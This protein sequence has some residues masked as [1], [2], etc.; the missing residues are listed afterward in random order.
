MRSIAH[1]NARYLRDRIALYAWE[2][3][4]RDKPWLTRDAVGLLDSW[5]RSNDTGLECGSGRS[6]V[7]FARRVAKMT[8]VEH[9]SAW[10]EKVSGR[11]NEAGV[12]GRVDFRLCPDGEA[13]RADTAYVGSIRRLAPASVDFVIID[14]VSRDHCALAAIPVLRPGGLLVVDNAN[15]Y[16]PRH[17]RSVAPNSRGLRDGFSSTEWQKF[18]DAVSEWRYVWTSNGITDTCIWLKPCPALTGE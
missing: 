3:A 18:G 2:R 4:N 11:L 1:W 15:W 8:S 13:E 7:W 10:F 16:I 17:P 5:I 9:S 6:T 14:G 12:A